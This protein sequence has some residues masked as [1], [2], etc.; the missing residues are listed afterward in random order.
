MVILLITVIVL[1]AISGIAIFSMVKF[2]EPGISTVE[3]TRLVNHVV[4]YNKEDN[5]IDDD[6]LARST[7]VNED[8]ERDVIEQY[9]EFKA[10]NDDTQAYLRIRNSNM[11]FPI[12]QQ[13]TVCGTHN[14][15]DNCYY[16]YRDIYKRSAVNTNSV[17]F[18]DSNNVIG[19]QLKEFDQNT[20]IYGHTWTNS[21]RNGK[22]PRIGD[23]Q[24]KQF[25]QLV[26]YTDMEWLK[27][28]SVL[29]LTTGEER[30]YW[31]PQNIVY[32]DCIKLDNPDGFN[33]FKRTLSQDDLDKLEARSVI[34]N[35]EEIKIDT[36]KLLTL[37]TCNYKYSSGKNT[38]FIVVFKNIQASDYNT[39]LEMASEIEYIQQDNLVDWK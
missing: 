8:I 33:Y 27:E 28:H 29:E 12:V 30:T 14:L 35:T 13:S 38:R 37:S 18:F 1:G 34:K 4:V 24:D 17:S 36:D 21:E 11:N 26:S 22:A 23:E 16:L 2:N 32:T 6:I 15:V 19:K 9:N 31:V 3:T 7:G 20:V 10:I 5:G 25:G 39:A